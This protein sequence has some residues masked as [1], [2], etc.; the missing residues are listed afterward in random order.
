MVILSDS[1]VDDV[2]SNGHWPSLA[3]R[4]NSLRVVDNRTGLEYIIPIVHNA[5]PAIAFKEMKSEQNKES[6]CDQDEY[7]LRIFDPGY[8]NTCVSESKITYK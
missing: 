6:P 7:G 1:K 5:I 3:N 4:S 2:R 8:Q